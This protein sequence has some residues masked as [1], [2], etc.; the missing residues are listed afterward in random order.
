LAFA[1]SRN[2]ARNVSRSR[3]YGRQPVLSGAFTRNA[4]ALTLF[5]CA[6]LEVFINS[7]SKR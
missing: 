5:H 3:T 2:R 6:L 7:F 1:F 4:K